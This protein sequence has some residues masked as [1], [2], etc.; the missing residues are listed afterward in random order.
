MQDKVFLDTNI[1]IYLYSEDETDKNKI[2]LDILDSY[3]DAI[4][5]N[6]VINEITNVLFKKFRLSAEDVENVV[7]EIDN[8]LRIVDNSLKTQI[9]AVRLKGKYGFQYYDALIVA[10]ALEHGCNILFSEDMQHGQVIEDSLR[11]INPF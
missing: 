1:I 4:I 3:N 8:S 5:S 9:K 11:I 2:A 7:L 10:T 6:Q